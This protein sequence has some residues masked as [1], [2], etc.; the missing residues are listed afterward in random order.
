M[1]L[2]GAQ[3]AAAFTTPQMQAV[4]V[5]ANPAHPE[6]P[7]LTYS[8]AT[9]TLKGIARN[10]ATQYRWDYGDGNPAMPWTNITNPYNLGVRH[11]YTGAVGQLF[12]AT[13]SVRNAVDPSTAATATYPIRIAAAAATLSSTDLSQTDVRAQ[14]AIDEALW[15]L[16]TSATR[17]Q[18]PGGSPYYAQPYEYWPGDSYAVESACVAADA[19]ELHGSEAGGDP[20]ADPYS[21]DAQRTLNFALVN[22][23]AAAIGPQFA[24]NP[25]VN[26]NGVGLTFPSSAANELTG[27]CTLA[28]EDSHAPDR[29]AATGP[30]GVQG[31]TYA[32]LTQDAVDW[33]AW[34]QN[35]S[36]SAMRGNWGYTANDS[37][38]SDGGMMRMP[39][40]ALGAAPRA[41]GATVP[42][43]VRTELA[44][45]LANARRTVHDSLN[46]GW[47]YGSGSALVDPGATADGLIGEEFAGKAVT[48]AEIQAAV[49]YF[50]RNW[51]GA[52][53]DGYPGCWDPNV[54]YTG[55]MYGF[56]RAM[57]DAGLDRV[58][59]YNYNTGAQTGLSFD[60]YY[61]P[62]G[63][64]QTGYAKDLIQRQAADGSWNDTTGCALYGHIQTVAWDTVILA[65]GAA[66]APTVDAGG[67][68]IGDKN[69]PI[70]FDA[71]RSLAADAAGGGLTYQWSLNG[72]PIPG[73]TGPTTS[74]S[75]SEYTSNSS[76]TPIATPYSVCV[77][78][79]DALG[80]SSSA[81]PQVV[82][83]PPPHPPTA[84]LAP[85]YQAYAGIPKQFDASA[86]SDPDNDP[87]TYAWDFRD[88]G[89]YADATGPTPTFTFA[90]PG[91][92]AI[93]MQATDHPDQNS[94]PYSAP[95]STSLACSPVVVSNPP[96]APAAPSDVTATAGDG[97]VSLSWSTVAGA[98]GYKVLRG[99]S[100][101]GES[102]TPV[103]TV[104]SGSYMDSAV[105]NGTT[106]YYEVVA[107]NSG[108]DSGASNEAHATPQVPAPAAPTGLTGTAGDGQVSLSWSAVSGATSYRVLRGSTPG[109]E[110]PTPIGTVTGTSYLDS[111]VTNGSTYY[112]EIVASNAGGDSGASNEAHATPQVP[113]P[114][115]PSGVTA[116]G[117]DGQ[118]SVDWSAV[119]GATT[120]EVLR[121]SSAGNE[122]PTPVAAVT[123][124]PY[125]DTDVTNGS[126]YYYEVVASNAGGDSAPSNE[127]HATPQVAAPGTPNPVTVVVG[128]G[129]ISLSWTAVPG[130]TSYQVLR[131]T[132]PGGESA[133]PIAS[134]TGS[135]YD[136]TT[137]SN[138]NSYYY[139]VIASNAGGTSGP[140]SEVQ[141]VP[142][143]PPSVTAAASDGQ[144]ALSW[145]AVPGATAYRVLRGTTPGGESS[146][147]IGVP[148]SGTYLDTG[149]SNG[150]AYYYRVVA[151][152]GNGASDPSSEAHATPQVAAPPAPTSLT[153]TGGNGQVSLSWPAVAGATSYKVLRG[154]TAGGEAATPIAT[155]AG[156][157]YVDTSVTNGSTYYYVVR[158]ANAGGDGGPSPEV[159][160]TPHAPPPDTGTPA[161]DAPPAN[162]Q[163][164]GSPG[165]TPH[166]TVGPTV[167][168]AMAGRP[169]LKNALAHGLLLNVG[170]SEACTMQVNLLL[171]FKSAH[172]LHLAAAQKPMK[173]G[174]GSASLSA[175]GQGKVKSTFSKTAR[176]RL[177]RVKTLKL[178]AQVVSTDAAGNVTMSSR[179]LTLR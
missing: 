168:V 14:M 24:G 103:G 139:E 13:L 15:Y 130:A 34:A 16:H 80:R 111:S 176:S 37:S 55:P 54:G 87:L 76:G 33:L 35:D 125:V 146:T 155:P 18:Y 163:P 81:C 63:Q 22:A 60:W 105:T 12:V 36:G 47:G 77:R 66:A 4:T 67:P 19:F 11:A 164:E 113:A 142:L 143:A 53:A 69:T 156:Q 179:A 124:G 99:T 135:S 56:S 159:Q 7:H 172:A 42:S 169:K 75:F 91:T 122:S 78:V 102:A 38:P 107:T 95:S 126:T 136:D 137:V 128:T 147:P 46:G 96:P 104:L 178:T 9:T 26:G 108:V 84:R 41:M 131:G 25:D 52:T 83:K 85:S 57:H 6:A 64:T 39:I 43:F 160:A 120:Y 5:P 32:S 123:N 89:T 49:G 3:S 134:P 20:Q 97:Q 74:L 93:C 31:R 79:T 141:G 116:T 161:Q 145:S 177:R 70:T 73:A 171:D 21:E 118:V 109:S 100:P 59:D 152:S 133:T 88:A 8:G 28:L 2:A 82:I 151:I 174:A 154:S 44:F 50:Y 148:A 158:A 30:S 48:S 61:T 65:K 119:P 114:S 153:A 175:A 27:A 94:N 129:R 150:T 45:Y 86:S 157:S 138:G 117:A 106:Y 144:V 165:S 71:S 92:Y 98:T 17:S 115:A 40:L 121:G 101:G 62:A 58:A 170:C 29:T 23:S 90:A 127:A 1:A 132:T 110:S 162:S 112:Y 140:S 72:T 51:N 166:D 10:G 68:Y 167:T 149:L 173:I